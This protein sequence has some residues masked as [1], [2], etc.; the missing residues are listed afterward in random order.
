MFVLIGHV[1]TKKGKKK[2][3]N[4]WS[5]LTKIPI[6]CTEKNEDRFFPKTNKG[7]FGNLEGMEKEKIRI[8]FFKILV[9]GSLDTKLHLLSKHIQ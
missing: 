1:Q 9:S 8:L 2:C 5:C 7:R 6:T 4:L 3:L